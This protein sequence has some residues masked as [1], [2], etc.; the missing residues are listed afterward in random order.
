MDVR[1]RTE[2]MVERRAASR[3]IGLGAPFGSFS[4]GF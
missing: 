4:P 2:C 1:V 3:E